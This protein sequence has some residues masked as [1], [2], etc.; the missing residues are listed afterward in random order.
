MGARGIATDGTDI[1]IADARR[2]Q[3]VRYSGAASRTSGSQRSNSSFR[4]AADNPFGITTDGSTIWVVHST[5]DRVYKYTTAGVLQ[6]EWPLHSANADPN[7]LTIDPS[8]ASSSV[9]VVDSVAD[10]V[11]EYDRDTGTFLGSFPLDT[12]AGNTW[13]TGIADPPPPTARGSVYEPLPASALPEPDG[14]VS[15][16]TRESGGVRA[17][18]PWLLPEP[19]P[20]TTRRDMVDPTTIAREVECATVMVN[21][22]CLLPLVPADDAERPSLQPNME[23]RQLNDF[24]HEE[25]ELLD[26]DLLALIAGANE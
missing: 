3:V 1:W 6:G 2:E 18:L 21:Y 17:D 14:A 9:W 8:G 20:N 4:L 25:T 23:S 16:V 19:W 24:A 26:D 12:T 7:G 5:T 13:A 22:N 10:T 11:F 15:L